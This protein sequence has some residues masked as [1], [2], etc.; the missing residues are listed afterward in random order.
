MVQGSKTFIRSTLMRWVQSSTAIV[1][2]SY[3]CHA[4]EGSIWERMLGNCFANVYRSFDYAQDDRDSMNLES[5]TLN[6]ELW[7][8]NLQT[9][10][11]PLVTNPTFLFLL[12]F[13]R[14]QYFMRGTFLHIYTIPEGQKTGNGKC[15]CTRAADRV[16]TVG[17][18]SS[19]TMLQVVL[20]VNR[21]CAHGQEGMWLKTGEMHNYT[22]TLYK[23]AKL[24]ARES[25]IWAR[26]FFWTKID[27][28]F[29]M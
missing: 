11:H 7:T 12:Y 10:L 9:S 25:R 14:G 15:V 17:W 29:N 4:D 22:I 26:L 16:H 1:Q 3:Y 24:T 6:L 13:I 2:G 27:E 5:W 19:D 18:V 20:T 23:Y 8:W 28:N 21:E